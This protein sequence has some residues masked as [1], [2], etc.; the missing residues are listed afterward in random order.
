MR[1]SY[2]V[3]GYHLSSNFDLGIPSARLPSRRT[4]KMNFVLRHERAGKRPK[5]RSESLMV[6]RFGVF[7]FYFKARTLEL[8]LDRGFAAEEIQAVILNLGIP[9]AL[10]LLGEL[11][12]HASALQTKRGAVILMGRRGQGKS[13]LAAL[14]AGKGIKILSDD[15]VRV[16]IGK[17]I[18]VHPSFPEIRVFAKD[19]VRHRRLKVQTRESFLKK[20][21]DIRDHFCSRPLTI[22]KIIQLKK[23]SAHGA[24]S[25]TL[26]SS[27][28]FR[29]VMD[30]VL[31]APTLV[32][33]AP[34]H[35]QDVVSLVAKTPVLRLHFSHRGF[36]LQK[37]LKILQA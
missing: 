11:I 32:A 15:M 12:I 23:Q 1:H 3:Y 19:L 14:A 30:N 35:F 9:F 29:C 37:V 6:R 27:E 31:H 25:E 22:D 28:A 17:N 7:S 20:R 33:C 24:V 34:K 18:V 4:P 21:L 5:G 8:S 26:R 16:Q 36:K 2:L 10:T 13:T